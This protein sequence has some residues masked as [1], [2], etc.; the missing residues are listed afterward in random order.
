MQKTIRYTKPLLIAVALAVMALMC[1]SCSSDDDNPTA[2]QSLTPALDSKVGVYTTHYRWGGANGAWRGQSTFEVKATGEVYYGS[3]QIVMPTIA[4]S[5]ITWSVADGNSRNG[6]ITFQESSTSD[7]FWRDK[8]GV[9]KRNFTG[10]IQNP[11]EGPL[12]F[13]GLIQ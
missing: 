8:G 9:T 5:T 11:G 12:D 4:D 7:F 2:P 6:G 1:V 10:W 3:T 13:R